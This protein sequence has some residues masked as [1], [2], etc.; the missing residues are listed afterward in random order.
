MRRFT[1]ILLFAALAACG[2]PLVTP[3]EMNQ[4][5]VGLDD[6]CEAAP[7]ANLIGQD[8][9]ALERTLR[10]GLVRVIR[11]GDMVT[12]DYRPERINFII[13]PDNTIRQITCG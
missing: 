3:L 10:M 2:A 5:P 4:V 7:L 9:T 12:Q 13:A 1:C 6:T 8:A 11:P